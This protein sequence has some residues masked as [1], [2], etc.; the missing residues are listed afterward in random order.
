MLSKKDWITLKKT[1]K[2]LKERFKETEDKLWNASTIGSELM[3]QISHLSCSILNRQ[4]KDHLVKPLKGTDK[5]IED[6]LA[7]VLFNLLNISNELKIDP[8]ESL[9][10]VNGLSEIA[11]QYHKK[12]FFPEESVINLDIQAGN[13]LDIILREEDY[14]HT[15]RGKN[16]N[17]RFLELTFGATLV[18]LLEIFKLYDID[19]VVVFG[20]MLKDATKFLIKLRESNL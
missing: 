2:A 14:K 12:T 8:Y 5:G 7:D 10:K 13:L 19:P 6:E 15:I 9:K 16:K 18:S 1:S 20:D 11:K 3:I 17:R 4:K